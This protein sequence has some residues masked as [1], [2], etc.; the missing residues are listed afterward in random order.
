MAGDRITLNVETGGVIPLPGHLRRRY[1][2]HE[3]ST[4]VAE[5]R[6]DGIL[7]RPGAV[8]PLLTYS[9]ERKAEFLLTNAVD[10]EDYR[11]ARRAVRAMG[12]D[13][14]EVYHRPPEVE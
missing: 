8:H 3:G 2:L 14:A 13:P 10:R 11:G 7:L 6:E 4:L 1:G 9:R 12:L 5:A